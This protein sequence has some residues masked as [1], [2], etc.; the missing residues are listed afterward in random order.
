MTDI[1]GTGETT[2]LFIRVLNR[3]DPQVLNPIEDVFLVNKVE[4]LAVRVPR[5]SPFQILENTFIDVDT[6]SPAHRWS[7]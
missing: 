7:R 4:T 5:M 3:N 1:K 6:G 2:R